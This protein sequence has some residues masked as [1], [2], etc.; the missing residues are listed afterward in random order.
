MIISTD[1][2]SP[3]PRWLHAATFMA[4]LCALPFG[5]VYC[6]QSPAP[7]APEEE[8]TVSEEEVLAVPEADADAQTELTLLR[9]RLVETR[10]RIRTLE[11]RWQ[12]D[13]TALRDARNRLLGAYH[14]SALPSR[15]DYQDLF[16]LFD[17]KGQAAARTFLTPRTE[18]ARFTAGTARTFRL[19]KVT[20]EI[21]LLLDG[22]K[23]PQEL[24]RVLAR[25][26]VLTT[27]P[28]ARR[29]IR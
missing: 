26:K 16:D 27:I 29:R 12:E 10:A 17:R 24:R 11:Q 3:A 14:A 25:L 15:Y 23:M 1:T 7:M 20:E 9:E 22:D 21:D 5:L 19:R 28:E 2:T 8:A 18:L 13:S 4:L 6:T